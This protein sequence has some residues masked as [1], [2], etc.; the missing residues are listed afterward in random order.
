M[1]CVPSAVSASTVTAAEWPSSATCRLVLPLL[2]H[3]PLLLAPSPPCSSDTSK[4][5]PSPPP[6]Y[7]ACS[8]GSTARQRSG[9]G[10]WNAAS[11][12]PA[13]QHIKDF[14][15]ILHQCTVHAP[16]G[17]RPGSAAAPAAGTLPAP[18]LQRKASNIMCLPPLNVQCMLPGIHGKAAQRRR[19]L[20][21]HQLHPCSDDLT[22]MKL[23]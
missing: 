10:R 9:A 12:S 17:R 14:V 6:R 18:H 21:R 5:R 7:S 20:N 4:M 3:P 22:D 2:P 16:P 15:L 1:S 13:G 8:P 11:P 19:L 23:G